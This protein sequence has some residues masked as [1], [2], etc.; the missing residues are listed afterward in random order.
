MNQ[1]RLA[2]LLIGFLALFTTASM[3][4]EAPKY[5]DIPLWEK[6]APTSNGKEGQA[7]D[8][9]KRIYKP[10]IRVFLPPKGTA[11]GRAVI[12]YP[13]GGYGM[14]AY[15]HEG[16]DFAPFFNNQGIAL[17]VLKYRMPYGHREVP[18]SD[19]EEA[20]RVVKQHAAEW[21]IKPNDIGIMGSSAG[22]HLASTYATHSKPELRPAFQILLYPVITMDSTYAHMGSRKNL[23]G[24]NP[25]AELLKNYSNEQ[26]VTSQTPRAFIVL[27]D[28]DK[29]VLPANS[30][31][32]YLALNKAGVP[33]ALHIYPT[34]GH[35]WGINE[36]FQYKQEF[37]L[38]LREWL[39]SF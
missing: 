35:G 9:E 5:I 33:A 6:G 12:T 34:G 17:I 21:N 29:V 3:A 26:Q 23:L 4:Q 37:L 10:M 1:I 31:N 14:L 38:E 19:A 24:N 8:E 18:F 28:D 39:R 2:G 11:T 27:S 7:P 25:S 15:H 20:M 30:V 16:Y 36:D 22:G 13:G 32:Y